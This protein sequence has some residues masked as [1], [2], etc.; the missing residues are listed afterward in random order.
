MKDYK[1]RL[2]IGLRVKL[3]G[4][5]SEYVVDGHYSPTHKRLMFCVTPSGNEYALGNFN[6]DYYDR[7]LKLIDRSAPFSGGEADIM[8]LTDPDTGECVFRRDPETG[9]IT[10]DYRDI[11]GEEATGDSERSADEPKSPKYSIRGFIPLLKQT[12]ALYGAECLDIRVKEP[13]P[14]DSYAMAIVQFRIPLSLALEFAE[15][16]RE[17]ITQP[18]LSRFFRK[19]GEPEKPVIPFYHSDSAE[20]ARQGALA[21]AQAGQ[22]EAAACFLSP[23]QPTI[24]G[25]AELHQKAAG[26]FRIDAEKLDPANPFAALTTDSAAATAYALQ[27]SG[28]ASAVKESDEAAARAFAG[29]IAESFRKS[30]IE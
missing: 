1:D 19:N 3:R 25:A 6:D 28:V 17:N 22:F 10:S 7:E 15:S 29:G 18:A 24:R 16:F 13:S 8:E 11:E 4:S 14:Y 27:E 20:L 30:G 5:E 9:A 23:R 2:D 26:A 12:G 21:F